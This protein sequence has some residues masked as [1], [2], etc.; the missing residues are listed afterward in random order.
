LLLANIL[1]ITVAIIGTGYYIYTRTNSTNV[2][3]TNRLDSIVL[4]QAR[5]QLTNTSALRAQELNNFFVQSRKDITKI[6][7]TAVELLSNEKAISTS[8]FWDASKQLTQNPNGTWGNSYADRFS[9]FIP[10]NV[11]VSP[12]LI[13]ELNTLSQMSFS[14]PEIL[15]QN[16]DATGVY[17]GGKS[18]EEIYFPNINLTTLLSSDYD[19]TSFPWYINASPEQNPSGN[20]V[21][22]TPYLDVTLHGLIVTTSIPVLDDTGTFRGVAAMDITLNRITTLVTNIRVGTS[23]YA[24]LIDN[25]KR[26]I[27]FSEGGYREFGFIS[28]TVPVGQ[29]MDATVLPNIPVEFF[30][31]LDKVVAGESGIETIN[32]LGTERY[33][34]YA[35]VPEIGYSLVIMAPSSE[36]LAEA[37]AARQLITQE[38]VNTYSRSILLGTIILII[39]II[40]TFLIGNGLTSPLVKLTKTAEEITR[41]N[42]NTKADIQSADEIGTLA[43]ALNTMT[44]TLRNNIQS[45]EQ[46]VDERTEDL[47]RKTLRLQA[48]SQIAHDATE[49]QDITTL[50]GRTAELISN[51][52]G[53]YH[54]GIFL[55]DEQGEFAVLLAASSEGGQRMLA[56]GHRLN[57]NQQGLVAAAARENKPYIIMDVEA[58]KNFLK[59]PD[60]PLTRSEATLP[61]V[62]RGKILGVLDIQSVEPNAFK[63]DDID[64]LRT[65]AD[66]IGL[67]IQ[68]ARSVVENLNSMNMLEAVLSGNVQATWGNELS[69]MKQTYHYSSSGIVPVS[70]TDKNPINKSGDG[71]SMDVPITLRG[72]KIG[73]ITL[74]RKKGTEWSDSEKSL[75]LEVSTQIGLALENARLLDETSRRADNEKTLSDVTTKIRS[76][77][78]PQFMI[79]V[80]K[81]ELKKILGARDVIIRPFSP[82]ENNPAKGN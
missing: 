67:A 33:I 44:S 26:L 35:P 82:G 78:T 22:S 38:T 55:L 81:E 64:I 25:S 9:A 27:A 4:K 42:I 3:L 60:L 53:F 6:G 34:S 54:T 79:D 80:A 21:W 15:K 56:R 76:V 14:V 10:A 46:K 19:V 45:L 57:I 39:A 16:P 48:A 51:R 29:T 18:K 73:E 49:M 28:P 1:I 30:T 74:L 61:L 37:A 75:A 70:Q 32:F 71:N 41:G 31:F 40:I 11:V 12:D 72:Q 69:K 59:N 7:T 13:S 17:F 24:F 47:V 68:N 77:N 50:I 58:D 23:G 62:A 52:F 2:I 65:M 63:E 66:Q 36:L 20:A 8:T 5:D 43:N